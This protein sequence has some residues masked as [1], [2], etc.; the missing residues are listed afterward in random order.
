[1]LDKGITLENA[2]IEIEKW[3]KKFGFKQDEICFVTCGDF[4]F[5]CLAREC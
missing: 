4:D 5:K 3:L 1:M 2:L